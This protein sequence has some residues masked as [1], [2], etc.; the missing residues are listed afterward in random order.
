MTTL[1][2]VAAVAA[3]TLANMTNVGSMS[4]SNVSHSTALSMIEKETVC[5]M[6]TALNKKL[7]DTA[8]LPTTQLFSHANSTLPTNSKCSSKINQISNLVSIMKAGHDGNNDQAEGILDVETV[9]LEQQNTGT[10]VYPE[11]GSSISHNVHGSAINDINANNNNTEHAGTNSAAVLATNGLS[12]LVDLASDSTS[13]ETNISENHPNMKSQETAAPNNHE[14]RVE[15]GPCTPNNSAI[16]DSKPMGCTASTPQPVGSVMTL[17]EAKQH[18]L[19][20]YIPW[21]NNTYG[22]TAKTKT[23]TNKKYS[24]IISLLRSNT[25]DSK[26]AKSGNGSTNIVPNDTPMIASVGGNSGGEL[27]KFKLWVKSKGFHLGPPLGHTDLGAPGT[28]NTLYLPT[29]TDKVMHFHY[30]RIFVEIAQLFGLN[31]L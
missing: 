11:K 27:A 1:T 6:D 22:D 14:G 25:S 15:I 3:Q 21:V 19:S 2:S 9:G 26:D 18:M 7:H 5:G 20:Q 16:L 10:H 23:I 28:E 8:Q 4:A 17:E 30:F 29:G 24:R 13:S 31:I 12:A